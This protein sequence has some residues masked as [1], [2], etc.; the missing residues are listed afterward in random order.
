MDGFYAKVQVSKA[1]FHVAW[2]AYAEHRAV[3]DAKRTATVPARMWM[4]R[5]WCDGFPLQRGFPIAGG[6][7]RERTSRDRDVCTLGS[8]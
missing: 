8:R 3:K 5:G 1:C 7:L 6:G 4:M 2:A